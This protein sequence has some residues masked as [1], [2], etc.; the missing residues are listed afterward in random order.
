MGLTCKVL[1]MEQGTDEW[2]SAR[3]G[4]FTASETG[5]YLVE[6]PEVRL[7][8]KEIK[9]ILDEAGIPYTSKDTKP[10]LV[11]KI[12]DVSPYLSVTEA[13][14]K[15]RKSLIRRKLALGTIEGQMREENTQQK[16]ERNYDI[17]RGNELEPRAREKYRE[18]MGF[19]VV[20]VGLCVHESSHFAT[21]GT[22]LTGFGC[23]PDGL[24]PDDFDEWS[25]GLEAKSP[26]PEKLM[27]W[28]E[29]G[30]LPDEHAAQVHHCMAT[31]GLRR[32]DFIGYCP[33]LP[34]FIVV[35]EW[36]E[37]TDRFLAE[38]QKLHAE[39]IEYRRTLGSKK[40]IVIQLTPPTLTQ[41]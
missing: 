3:R 20:E 22:P 7:E 1:T 10:A 25:H 28:I 13:S 4:I 30:I 2:K 12:P 14:K 33:E 16:L 36:N 32:W 39:F 18:L 15:S 26:T 8:V 40:A 35:T 37:I 27:E 41:P 11:S 19:E 29:G 21:D 17:Q 9:A 31:T 6:V 38:L 34:P 23:S 5:I 24:I